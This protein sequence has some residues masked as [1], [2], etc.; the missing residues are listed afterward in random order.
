MQRLRLAFGA[1]VLVT[2]ALLAVPGPVVGTG[3]PG[4]PP[5]TTVVESPEVSPAPAPVY[6]DEGSPVI[7]QTGTVL[8]MTTRFE[9]R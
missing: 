3:E 2:G 5:A 9:V 7:A 1:L 6:A 8:P 4:S